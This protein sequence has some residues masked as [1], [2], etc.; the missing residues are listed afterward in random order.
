MP[1]IET[2]NAISGLVDSLSTFA[3]MLFMIIYLMK[4]LAVY[5]SLISSD[6]QRRVEDE[7][8]NRFKLRVTQEIANK[9]AGGGI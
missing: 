6:W 9:N 3:F 7:S 8:D 1:E 4:K 5:E 2:L